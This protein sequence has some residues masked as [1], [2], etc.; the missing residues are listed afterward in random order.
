MSTDQLRALTEV[1]VWNSENAVLAG[2]RVA[3]SEIHAI[4]A[5]RTRNAAKAKYLAWAIEFEIA[6]LVVLVAAA[7]AVLLGY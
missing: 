4:E 3:E 1:E 2:R 6:G 5:A 7:G